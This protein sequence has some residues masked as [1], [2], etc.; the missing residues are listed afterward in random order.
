MAFI[1]GTVV[2]VALPA[3]QKSLHAD[4]VGVQWI[5][6]SYGLFLS[7]LILAGGA[8]GDSLGRRKVFLGGTIL[9]TLAS[10]ACGI[11]T[12]LTELL[13]ARC[14]QGIGAAA[15]VPGSLALISAA[16]DEQS[17]GRAIGTWSG[18]TAM[19]TAFGPVLGGWFV[20]H[21]S[22]HWVFLM[23]VP[24]AVLVIAISLKFVPESRN[25]DAQQIDWAGAVLATLCLG[26]LVFGFV[27]SS[28]LGWKSGYVIGGIVLGVLLLVVFVYVERHKRSPMMPLDLFHS[29]DFTGANLLTLLLYAAIGVF[30]FVFALLAIQVQHYSPFAT[31]AASLP[32]I[33]LMFVLSRWSGG[34]VARY[35]ARIPLIIG[36]LIAAGG[37]LLFAYF[38]AGGPYARTLLPAFL[39]LGFGLAISVAPLTT[40]VMDSAKSERAGAASGINNAVARVAGVVAIAVFGVVMVHAFGNQMDRSLQHANLGSEALTEM[41]Q[42]YLDMG[43]MAVPPGLDEQQSQA[44]EDARSSAFIFAFREVMV[45]CAV[46][47][48]ASA[49]VSLRMITSKQPVPE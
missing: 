29:R 13:I 11:S 39:V 44:V 43:A 10:V 16:Y 41:R 26:L 23:N 17:R 18:F 15:L 32:F 49:A 45:I 34:L 25:P 30:F 2:N 31:G 48:I 9:F 40:V 42:H 14:V 1:D 27:E 47:A 8:L 33:L 19:T 38:A 20:E 5:V 46:L 37:F 12:N 3:L 24:L 28:S 35:G 4:V 21:A 36:P 7:A 6:E 22:W